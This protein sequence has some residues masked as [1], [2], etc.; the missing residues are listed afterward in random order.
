LFLYAILFATLVGAISGIIP[1][2]NASKK[3]P[4]DSLR[5]E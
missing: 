5:Y 1:A 4:V 3:N 2:F